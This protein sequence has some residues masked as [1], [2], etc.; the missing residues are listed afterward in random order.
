VLEYL[1][2]KNHRKEDLFENYTV[3]QLWL[4]YEKSLIIRRKEQYEDALVFAHCMTLP[5]GGEKAASEFKK[6]VESLLPENFKK[7]LK[8]SERA[9]SPKHRAKATENPEHFLRSLGI[10][11]Q[12]L[13][14]PPP[15]V[16]KKEEKPPIPSKE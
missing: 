13:K 11:V 5:L 4:F 3:D 14:P 15:K 12:P 10:P 16:A 6:F 2:E 1:I 7:S 9:I 8:S